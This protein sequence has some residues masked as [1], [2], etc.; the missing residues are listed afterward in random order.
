MNG[1]KEICRCGHHKDTHFK[2]EST[3]LGMRCDCLRYRDDSVP[4][5]P[6]IMWSNGKAVQ[7]GK[8]KRPHNDTSCACDACVDWDAEMVRRLKGFWGMGYP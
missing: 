4:E 7:H 8:R 1:W 6:R 2:S 5:T 3:C